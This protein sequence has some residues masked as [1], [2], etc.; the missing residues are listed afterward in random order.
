MKKLLFF[1]PFLTSFLYAAPPTPQSLG[2]VSVKSITF[3]DST[4]LTSTASIGGGG[5]VPGGLNGQIQFNNGGTFG[6]DA[7]LT[8]SSSTDTGVRV[9]S[10]TIGDVLLHTT[11]NTTDGL[12][13]YGLTIQSL[14]DNARI[15]RIVNSANQVM[16]NFD[17]ENQR[18]GFFTNTPASGVEMNTNVKIDGTARVESGI[19]IPTSS[20]IFSFQGT[21]TLTS[22]SAVVANAIIDSTWSLYLT[23]QSPSG[24]VGA[25]Y[26]S[27]ITA[28]TSFNILSTSNADN[29]TFSWLMVQH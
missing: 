29:S 9:S 26:V 4:I 20:G 3:P 12:G 27:S 22:G 1:V 15:F 11:F 24:T 17:A 16:F 28:N 18:F 2:K 25:L 6:G 19:R 13:A 14:I 8:Y 5:G 10:I 21:A 23:N 7:A